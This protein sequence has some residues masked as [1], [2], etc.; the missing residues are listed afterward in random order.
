MKSKYV[1]SDPWSI[2]RQKRTC[3][4]YM[5][6]KNKNN[7]KC[8]NQTN[9]NNYCRNV[10]LTDAF[11][12]LEYNAIAANISIQ[13]SISYNA[14][15][16]FLV[17]HRNLIPVSILRKSTVGRYRPVRVTDGPIT[18]HYRFIKNASWD[19]SSQILF[20]ISEWKPKHTHMAATIAHS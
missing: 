15:E 6:L 20:W 14:D 5:R 12:R 7:D 2:V 8:L 13:F 1:C 9:T 10:Y 17:W 4:I 3:K 19:V 11:N 18:A 16:P